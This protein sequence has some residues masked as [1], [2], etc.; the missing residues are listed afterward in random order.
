MTFDPVPSH[1]AII[2]SSVNAIVIPPPDIFDRLPDVPHFKPLPQGLDRAHR[3]KVF[4]PARLMYEHDLEEASHTKKPCTGKSKGYGMGPFATSSSRYISDLLEKY[5]L[6]F[7]PSSP[8][9][10]TTDDTKEE[11]EEGRS[12]FSILPHHG[13]FDQPSHLY[14]LH[15]NAL[16]SIDE[17]LEHVKMRHS[18]VIGSH[19]FSDIKGYTVVA[20]VGGEHVHTYHRHGVHGGMGRYRKQAGCLAGRFVMFSAITNQYCALTIAHVL[21][22]SLFFLF[23][24]S[25][26]DYLARFDL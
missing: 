19:T 16:Q 20:N 18:K 17:W 3:G 22:F 13:Q 15:G 25:F 8:N 21:L 9:P 1:S 2:L 12:D 6:G 24:L 7:K 23:F 4:A 11:L 5:G 26:A 10:F 14:E